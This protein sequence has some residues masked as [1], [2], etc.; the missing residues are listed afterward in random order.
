MRSAIENT[1]RWCIAISPRNSS[2]AIAIYALDPRLYADLSQWDAKSLA[3]RRI[4][5]S[6]VG[7]GAAAY[8]QRLLEHFDSVRG[9][10][11]ASP[12]ALTAVVSAATAEEIRRHFE[13]ERL[14]DR[15]TSISVLP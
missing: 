4:E 10:R 2:S 8:R 14:P 6:H 5:G 7:Q 9:I 11:Q 1:M 3:R 15:V 13:S 12:D